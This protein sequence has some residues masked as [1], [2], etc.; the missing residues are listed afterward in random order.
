MSEIE[1]LLQSVRCNIG[2]AVLLLTPI[3]IFVLLLQRKVKTSQTTPPAMKTGSRPGVVHRPFLSG[4]KW[5]IRRFDG[6]SESAWAASVY[7]SAVV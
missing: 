3:F 6:L 7:V 5:L 4:K 1:V 2:L